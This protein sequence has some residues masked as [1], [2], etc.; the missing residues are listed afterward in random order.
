MTLA[1]G[2]IGDAAAQE[3]K[4]IIFVWD[5]LRPDS[6]NPADTPVLTL[7][8]TSKTLPLRDLSD[9]ADTLMAQR[10]SEVPGVGSVSVQGGLKPAVR[11]QVDLEALSSYGVSV[12]EADFFRHYARDAYG[13][14]IAANRAAGRHEAYQVKAIWT[15]PTLPQDP[16]LWRRDLDP[17]LKEKLRQ[18]FQI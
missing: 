3:R 18:F 10:L 1:I 4:I 13:G 14:V 6:I 15:S 17:A 2:G 9:L 11:V 16:I 5:G 7:A 12:D 8:L